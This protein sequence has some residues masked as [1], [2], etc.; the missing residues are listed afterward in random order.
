MSYGQSLEV[1]LFDSFDAKLSSLKCS[2]Q[3]TNSNLLREFFKTGVMDFFLNRGLVVNNGDFYV[4]P[5]F[6]DFIIQANLKLHADATYMEVLNVYV[7]A[8]KEKQVLWSC[9][10]GCQDS[11]Y[12][13]MGAAGGSAFFDH[14]PIWYVEKALRAE[15][16]AALTTFRVSHFAQGFVSECISGAFMSLTPPQVPATESSTLPPPVFPAPTHAPVPPGS[17]PGLGIGLAPPSN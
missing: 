6:E 1:R 2:T 15:T 4:D 17:A 13:L 12:R 3:F 9:D 5:V 8:L 14:E 10:Q 7:D 11:F 16:L